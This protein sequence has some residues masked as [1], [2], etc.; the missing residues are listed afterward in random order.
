MTNEEHGI[1]YYECQDHRCG[2]EPKRFIDDHH[3]KW[4]FDQLLQQL[5]SEALSPRLLDLKFAAGVG[6]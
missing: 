1:L 6:V 4:L 2:T 5:P 3:R